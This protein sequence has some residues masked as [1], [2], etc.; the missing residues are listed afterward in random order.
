MHACSARKQ[1]LCSLPRKSCQKRPDSHVPEQCHSPDC[2]IPLSRCRC[3]RWLRRL[4][5]SGF[6]LSRGTSLISRP[7]ACAGQQQAQQ[8]RR[9]RRA[10]L[11][12]AAARV[13]R[14][15]DSGA[16]GLAHEPV[17]LPRGGRR[18]RLRGRVQRGQRA[19]R[20]QHRAQ[21][22]LTGQPS[23]AAARFRKWLGLP[24]QATC[25]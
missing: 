18:R 16:Q 6:S 3:F 11:G 19:Q 24:D 12:P 25:T 13:P 22:R 21:T 1:V 9:D 17:V 15:G 7:D 5:C 14:G 23:W 2:R 4:P 10:V 20:G 8:R